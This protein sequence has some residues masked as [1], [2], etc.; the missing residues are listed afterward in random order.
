M[1]NTDCVVGSTPPLTVMPGDDLTPY[2][3]PTENM[4]DTQNSE[5]SNK[6]RRLMTP[7]KLG[8]GLHLVEHKKSVDTDSQDEK[9]NRMEIRVTHAGQ[10]V[11]PLTKNSKNNTWFVRHSTQRYSHPM[12]GDLVVGVVEEKVSADYY[13]VNIGAPHGALLHHLEFDGATKRNKPQLSTGDLLYARVFQVSPFMDP[14]LTCKANTAANGD[15]TKSVMVGKDWMTQEC[16]FGEL[17]TKQKCVSGSIPNPPPTSSSLPMP[18][19]I[20][21]S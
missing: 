21:K 13:R 5:R 19:V 3:L 17:K 8:F 10:L 11:N 15:S 7:P 20:H 9:S 18:F 1:S 4:D 12:V 16:L 6:K 2:I 14:L